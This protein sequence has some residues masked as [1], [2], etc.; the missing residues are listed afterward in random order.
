MEDVH[1][2]I[3]HFENTDDLETSLTIAAEAGNAL[4]AENK[5][6]RQDLHAL[7]L[8]NSQLAKQISNLN[9]LSELTYQAKIEKLESQN[10]SLLTRNV[11]LTDALTEIENQLKEKQL[12]VALEKAF[13]EQDAD[14]ISNKI[15][16][17]T[18]LLTNTYPDVL[19]ITEHGLSKSNLE[20]TNLEGYTLIESF[21]RE[22]HQKGGVAILVKN[23]LKNYAS[24]LE[25]NIH[26]QELGIFPTKLKLAKV[27]PKLKK[28][29][30]TQPSNYRPISLLPAI[31]KIIEKIELSRLLNHLNTNN[32]LPQ[33][34]HGFMGGK[35][36]STGLTSIVKYLI[37]AIDKGDTTTAIFLDFTKAF[38]CLSHD[39]LVKKLKARGVVAKTAD[40]FT[41]YLTDRMQT[42]EIRSPTPRSDNKN[43][44][45]T[46][47]QSVEESH[48]AQFWAPY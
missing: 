36:T 20:N 8:R 45:D 44:L 18:D 24:G 31:F 48:K 11:M 21:C 1:T 15:D 47:G 16:M 2:K 39:M 23:E 22:H 5:K 46:T 7:T 33:E 3:Q 25:R 37:K 29:D 10:E 41:S 42:V 34:Q 4:L 28:G 32:L 6:L 26:S 14:R 40:W 38:D 27:Y 43:Y 12:Q 17:M 19:I 30:P 13:E 35:S 9:T